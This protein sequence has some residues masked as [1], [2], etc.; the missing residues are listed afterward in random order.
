MRGEVLSYDAAAGAGL[1]SGDDGGRYAFTRADLQ[2]LT[3]LRAGMRVDFV[4]QDGRAA[5]V[6]VVA[7]AFNAHSAAGVAPGGAFDWRTLFLEGSGRIGQRDFWIGFAIL[8]V[9]GLI[10]GMIPIIGA[11][12]GLLLIYPW[13]CLYAKR[14]HDFGKSGWLVL[15]PVGLQLLAMLFG[16][17]AVF[18]GMIGAASSYGDPG[19]AMLGGVGAAG[20]LGLLSLIATIAFVLWVGLTKGDPGDNAYGPPRATPL[21]G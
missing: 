6:I 11:L 4:V 20:A 9:A 16:L 10:I 8:F 18:G 14:L 5:E 15:I 17:M 7:G 13:V 1:I 12:I 2:Q 19:M 3:P 21:V